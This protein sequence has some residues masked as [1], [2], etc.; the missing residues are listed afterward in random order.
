M[1]THGDLEKALNKVLKNLL[2]W[3]HKWN[4]LALINII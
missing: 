1:T 2:C 3:A 4:S